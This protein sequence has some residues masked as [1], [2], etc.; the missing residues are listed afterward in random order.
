MGEG[1][2]VSQEDKVEVMTMALGRV[3]VGILLSLRIWV[4][5]YL[6]KVGLGAIAL[7]C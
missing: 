7:R 2:E 3:R 5:R 6:L 1:E 4:W